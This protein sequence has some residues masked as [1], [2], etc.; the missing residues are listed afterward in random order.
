MN[1]AYFNKDL[2]CEANTDDDGYIRVCFNYSGKSECMGCGQ[3]ADFYDNEGYLMGECC[4]TVVFCSVCG[5]S[6]R[7]ESELICVD[8]RLLCPDCFDDHAAQDSITGENHLLCNMTTIRLVSDKDETK[9]VE[10]IV[11]HDVEASCT[12]KYF[13]AIR[14]RE[15][16]NRFYSE[17]YY[18]VYVSDCTNE[19]L[20]L[21]GFKEMKKTLKI[22]AGCRVWT[23]IIRKLMTEWLLTLPITGVNFIVPDISLR[24]EIC[25]LQ[26]IV[27][28]TFQWHFKRETCF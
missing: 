5:K 17:P 8:G 13:K 27:L 15:I 4:D 25:L 20:A 12:A 24:Q 22:Q 3:E 23:K 18:Y 28:E 10:T 16:L 14:K 21:F 6:Y 1:A 2:Y 19:G 11:V 7:S 26:I 9:I